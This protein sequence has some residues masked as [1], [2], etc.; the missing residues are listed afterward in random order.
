MAYFLISVVLDECALQGPSI[1]KNGRCT[2]L[3]EGFMCTCNSGFERKSKTECVGMLF[4]FSFHHF[5]I[6]STGA[7][8]KKIVG[9]VDSHNLRTLKYI[10]IDSDRQ[11]PTS[12]DM[13]RH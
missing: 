10:D 9:G 4:L 6:L 2:D 1:C 3:K 5:D 13:D 7:K 11:A 8:L 12:T